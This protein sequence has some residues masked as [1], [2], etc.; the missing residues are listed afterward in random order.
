MQGSVMVK[1]WGSSSNASRTQ[2]EYLPLNDCS[3]IIANCDSI[4]VVGYRKFCLPSQLDQIPC[5]LFCSFELNFER[6]DRRFVA[7]LAVVVVMML[8]WE[9]SKMSE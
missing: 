9:I 5:G 3:I 7:V 2:I 6:K 8:R 4:L 1:L